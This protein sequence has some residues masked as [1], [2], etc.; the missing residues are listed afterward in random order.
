MTVMRTHYPADPMNAFNLALARAANGIS[1]SY[2]CLLWFADY[3]IDA[4]GFDPAYDW[5]AVEWNEASS[6]Q[7]MDE[8]GAGMDGTTPVAR[9]LTATARRHGWER[10]TAAQQG[11]IM[12]GAYAF[13]EVGVAAVFDGDKRWAIAHEDGLRITPLPPERMWVIQ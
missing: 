10:V 12:V 2:P 4:T 9:A 6:R 3:V 13:G 8:I 11:S 5:R 7:I 1:W